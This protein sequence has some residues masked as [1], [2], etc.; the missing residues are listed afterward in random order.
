MTGGRDSVIG[1]NIEEPI[2]R[3]ITGLPKRFRPAGGNPQLCGVVV[4][5]DERNGRAASILRIQRAP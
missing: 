3:F 2:A 1:M 4:E 5:I